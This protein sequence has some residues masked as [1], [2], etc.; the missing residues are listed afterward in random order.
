MMTF[1]PAV[2]EGW[3]KRSSCSRTPACALSDNLMKR[4]KYLFNLSE[5]IYDED[6]N[7]NHDSGDGDGGGD[8]DEDD[9]LQYT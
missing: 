8:D 1:P 7:D 2:D 3:K 4:V 5:K 6:G 9:D